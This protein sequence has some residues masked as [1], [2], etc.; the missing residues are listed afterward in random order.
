M[1]DRTLR[2][3]QAAFAAGLATLALAMGTS[4]GPAGAAPAGEL[5]YIAVGDSYTAG[6]G[7]GAATKPAGT[8]CWQSSPGYVGD[9]DKTGRVSLVVN[10]ACHGALLFSG[11]DPLQKQISVETQ[12]TG[13]VA[14]QKLNPSTGIVTITAGAN[15]AGVSQVLGACAAYGVEVCAGAVASSEGGMS[16]VGEALAYIYGQIHAAAPSAK[17][18]VLGYPRLFEPADGNPYFSADEQRLIN[19][20]TD[21]LNAAIATAVSNANAFGAN[22]QFVDVTARFAGHAVNSADPWIAYDGGNPLADS[23]FHPTP[24]GHRAYA[25]AVMSEVK[26]GTLAR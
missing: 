25:T 3:R 20:A 26:P 7:A 13:L 11:D 14:A 23:N 2:R 24:T 12:L 15:D 18:A 5:D 22:A 21:K 9:V 4:A 10:A 8:T 1:S 17:V 16:Q 19:Q 6:T